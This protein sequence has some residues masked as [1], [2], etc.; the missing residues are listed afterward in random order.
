MIDIRLTG[1]QWK[2][3][4][5]TIGED[6]DREGIVGYL[7]LFIDYESS[8]LQLAEFSRYEADIVEQIIADELGIGVPDDL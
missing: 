6:S 3:V 2:A 1:P 5:D 8:E 7:D 4:A